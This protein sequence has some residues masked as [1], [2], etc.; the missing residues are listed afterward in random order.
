[1]LLF[2]SLLTSKATGMD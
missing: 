1:L 2:F